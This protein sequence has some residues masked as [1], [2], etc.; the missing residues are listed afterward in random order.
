MNYAIEFKRES[1]SHL[2]AMARKRSLKHKWLLVRSGLALIKM[3][4]QEFCLQPN[5]SFWIPQNS[6]C[7]IT[8]FPGTQLDT[9]DVSVRV[10]ETFPYSAGYVTLSALSLAIFNK[11]AETTPRSEEQLE[12]LA[13]LK[14][15]ATQI[16]PLF[17]PSEL[18]KQL[19]RWSPQSHELDK[20]WHMALLVRE[21]QKRMLSGGKKEQ[22]VSELFSG[23]EQQC[24]VICEMLLGKT[25]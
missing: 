2:T 23:D 19:S 13:V 11:L 3:G 9:L 14:R 1:F 18:C 20:E 6:L 12:L 22:V 7:S 24:N 8:L 21:A 4:K 25:L 17:K 16:R 15:E 10:R 5:Q